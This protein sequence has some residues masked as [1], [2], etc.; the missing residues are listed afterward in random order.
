MICP[1]CDMPTVIV[2]NGM[3]RVQYPGEAYGRPVDSLPDDVSS[4]YDEMRKAYQAGAYTACV[5]LSRKL[6]MHI[7]VEAGAAPGKSFMEYVS[8]LDAAGYL[9]PNG[10]AWVDRIRSMANA[11]NHELG[12]STDEDARMLID[13]SSMVLQFS[14]EY[15][16]MVGAVPFQRD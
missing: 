16:A 5:L 8:Y 4:V 1:H 12:L 2:R 3:A 7:A 11:A 15:P 9:P 10:K 14:Y 13:F 6:L